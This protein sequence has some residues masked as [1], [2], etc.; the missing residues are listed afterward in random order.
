M[1]NRARAGSAVTHTQVTPAAASGGGGT[2]DIDIRDRA[3]E[4]LDS[5][6]SATDQIAIDLVE[7]LD[8]EV[9]RL[10]AEL[11]EARQLDADTDGLLVASQGSV[12]VLTVENERLRAELAEAN[13]V[14]ERLN[15]LEES[16]IDTAAKLADAEAQL[17]EAHIEIRLSHQVEDAAL[18]QL[19]A[20]GEPEIQT[21]RT[22]ISVAG[23]PLVKPIYW[24]DPKYPNQG[25]VVRQA[26][27]T[28]WISR[29]DA[30]WFV[31]SVPPSPTQEAN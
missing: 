30:P 22:I 7:D 18:A 27:F 8:D 12:A 6:D 25:D 29:A 10:R 19:A 20:L 13:Q 17:A 3:D 5:G 31:E 14:I 2:P 24:I 9:A 16:Y 4:W 26:R 15:W 1:G 23:T 21:A 11:A 28:P